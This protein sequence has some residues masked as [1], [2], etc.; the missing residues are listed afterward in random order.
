MI[1]EYSVET[2]TVTLLQYFLCFW[3]TDLIYFYYI[4]VPAGGAELMN[5]KLQQVAAQTRRMSKKKEYLEDNDR[6]PAFNDFQIPVQDK[7]AVRATHNTLESTKDSTIISNRVCASSS[8]DVTIRSGSQK[9]KIIPNQSTENATVL[10]SK[11]DVS[12]PKYVSSDPLSFKLLEQSSR[13]SAPLSL[14]AVSETDGSTASEADNYVSVPS[15]SKKGFESVGVLTGKGQRGVS[16]VID[17]KQISTGV[18]EDVCSE[19]SEMMVMGMG[20]SSKDIVLQHIT[21]YRSPL[22][23]FHSKRQGIVL[24]VGTTQVIACISRT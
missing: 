10:V 21:E 16:T 4:R 23:H 20:S 1:F 14:S 2:V 13:S 6:N 17:I 12:Q 15:K 24:K 19:A 5:L 11:S 9:S 18:S 3:M 7:T 22:E 8:V